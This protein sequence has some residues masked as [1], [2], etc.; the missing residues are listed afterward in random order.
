M[1]DG[2]AAG[3]RVI[4]KWIKTAVVKTGPVRV[5][6][7]E[8]PVRILLL[9]MLTLPCFGQSVQLGVKGGVPVTDAFQASSFFTL[10]FGSSGSSATR[11]YT[12]GPMVELQL[13]HGFGV[14]C[15]ALY[16]RLG[17]AYFTKMIALEYTYS[18]TS[19]NGW[20][21]P[22]L[23]KYRLPKV[24]PFQPHIGIGPAFRTVTGVSIS[25]FSLIDFYPPIPIGRGHS[26]SDPHLDAR[27]NVGI[28][29][30]SGV[31]FRLGF[32]KV[33]PEVRYVR[34]RADHDED[35]NLHSNPNQVE[36]LLGVTF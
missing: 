14:E 23:A 7:W 1:R 19:A 4:R 8:T 21:F 35:P 15:D 10:D 32:L 9:V 26:S 31:E 17:F 28:A 36:V 22:L 13:P 18:N 20:E 33:S 11:R 6:V 16:T 25:T 27:S 3:G 29:V 2:V 24:H 30:G 12:V 34:W 5:F